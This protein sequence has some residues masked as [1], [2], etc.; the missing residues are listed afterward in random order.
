MTQ[1]QGRNASFLVFKYRQTD[2]PMLNEN[3]SFGTSVTDITGRCI[4]ARS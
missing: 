1:K 3:F 2:A 4:P